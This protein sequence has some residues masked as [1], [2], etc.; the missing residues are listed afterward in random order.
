VAAIL[1]IQNPFT[2]S[3]ISE[4]T[5][6]SGTRVGTEVG[7]LAPNFRLRGL[8][9]G[10]FALSDFRGKA[11]VV[12]FWATWCPFCVREMPEFEKAH[13]QYGDKLIILGVNR[14]E[15]IDKQREF[16]SKEL[17]VEITYRLLLDPSDSVAQA[18]GVFGMPTTF[19]LDKDGVIIGKRVGELNFN[20]IKQMLSGLVE[21]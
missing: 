8:N 5:S 12:N 21:G 18:Y 15:S 4:Q 7:F 6:T 17:P 16:L 10:E 14:A 11:V 3:P 19:F 13:K 20:Q 2:A 9:G 1:V